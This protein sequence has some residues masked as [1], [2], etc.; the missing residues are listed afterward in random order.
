[1]CIIL[2][3][4]AKIVLPEEI[5]RNCFQNND[6]G[7]GMAFV[8][9]EELV[10]EKGYFNFDELYKDIKEREQQ[11][12]L[13]HFRVASQGMVINAEN[14]HPFAFNSKSFEDRFQFAIVHNGR[15][16][17]R[18]EKDK[19]DT[20]CFT[21]D[22]LMQLLDQNPYAL[23][24]QQYYKLLEL[25]INPTNT[26]NNKIVVMRYDN[27]EK[28]INTFFLNKKAG[29]EHLGC[30]F[31]NH[32]YKERE[33]AVGLGGYGYGGYQHEG[34]LLNFCPAWVGDGSNKQYM[35]WYEWNNLL[36]AKVR[37]LD[38]SPPEGNQHW[39][40]LPSAMKESVAI[41]LLKIVPMD[42]GFK[43]RMGMNRPVV[44]IKPDKPDK[45]DKV[46]KPAKEHGKNHQP[47]WGII[48]KGDQGLKYLSRAQRKSLYHIAMRYAR[49]Q[50][51][52]VPDDWTVHQSIRFMRNDFML[53]VHEL[54]SLSNPAID[55]Y[56]LAM[57]DNNPEDVLE[58]AL[59]SL[60]SWDDPEVV[61][62]P[63]DKVVTV[64]DKAIAPTMGDP[65]L[66]TEDSWKEKHG[67]N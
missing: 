42:K 66:L 63:E 21:E 45:P 11:E 18:T 46:E 36:E 14:C 8:Q 19:S 29:V 27:K 39:G 47:E 6:D 54:I 55:K 32:S 41:Q 30:W 61:K 16:P 62:K 50:T 9:E 3:K 53:N 25:Y 15:L 7:A 51:R 23:Q 13:I 40:M 44:I 58:I 28:A 10:V 33:N 35:S 65:D 34:M 1:M 37:Q 56:I 20:A 26:Q 38:A 24:F 43:T 4:P 52:Y 64:P 57:Y 60:D 2:H 49:K 67:A 22:M 48:D 17:Y 12:L 59:T 31:S 5:Y